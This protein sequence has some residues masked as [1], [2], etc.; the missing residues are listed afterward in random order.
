M[1]VDNSWKLLKENCDSSDVTNK[2]TFISEFKH[3]TAQSFLDSLGDSDLAEIGLLSNASFLGCLDD[4]LETPLVESL[5]HHKS[6]VNANIDSNQ[7]TDACGALMNMI[8]EK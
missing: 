7:I 2:P 1:A 4:N 6:N 3:Y 5:R 8:S